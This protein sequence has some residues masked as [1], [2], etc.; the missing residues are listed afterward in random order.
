MMQ[1]ASPPPSPLALV[2][3]EAKV[4][5]SGGASSSAGSGAPVLFGFDQ[6]SLAK[7]GRR[8]WDLVPVGLHPRTMCVT[9]GPV[10]EHRGDPR[11]PVSAVEPEVSGA[12]TFP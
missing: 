4:P 7:A 10:H 1:G 2:P 6:S 9:T 5:P 11:V 12:L 3:K 8:R